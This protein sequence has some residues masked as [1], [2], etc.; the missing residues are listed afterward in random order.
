M[1]FPTR[2]DISSELVSLLSVD[3]GRMS[4]TKKPNGLEEST[5]TSRTLEE[6]ASTFTVDPTPTR[7]TSF[8]TTAITVLTKPGTLIKRVFLIQD[9]HGVIAPDSKSDQRCLVEEHFSIKSTSVVININLELEITCQVK[10]N[11]G[12]SSTRELEP[13][14]QL[15]RDPTPLETE[16]DTVTESVNLLSSDHTEE[17]SIKGLSTMVEGT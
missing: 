17:R 15:R 1:P 11:N 8:S 12:S 3:N 7:D 10:V 9:N 13:S 4:T 14:D 16:K 2:E 5:E 6:S